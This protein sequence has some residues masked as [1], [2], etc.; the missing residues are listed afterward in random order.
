ML[1]RKVLSLATALGF[2]ISSVAIAQDATTPPPAAPPPAAPE[3]AVVGEAPA[4]APAAAAEEKTEE[5]VVTGTRIRRKDLTTPAPVT[6]ISSEQIQ[7]SGKVTIG[8]FLQSLPEQGN[9]I[10]T[11]VNNGGSGSTR[12]SLRALGAQRTLVLLNGRRMVPSGLGA[13]D[14]VDLSAIPSAVI[15]RVEVLKDGAS[16]VY[17]SDAIAGVVNLI[18]RKPFSGSEVSGYYG[19]SAQGDAQIADITGT[20]GTSGERGSLFFNVGWYDQRKSMAGDRDFSKDGWVYDS[21]GANTGFLGAVPQGSSR[22]PG[23]RIRANNPEGNANPA[24]LA[25]IQNPDYVSRWRAIGGSAYLIHD[26]TLTTD[27][28]AVANCMAALP[29][30]ASLSDCQWRPMDTRTSTT[31]GGDLYNF[32]PVNYL[33]TPSQRLSLWS[34]GDARLSDS[35]RAFFEAHFVNRQ[36]RVQL[37]PEPLIIGPGGVTDPGGNLVSIS[38]DNVYN[39]FGQKF[40]LSSR[41]LEE[42]GPRIQRHDVDTIRAV[43]GVDGTLSDAF[44]PVQGWFWDVNFNYGRNAST[45]T[46]NGNLQNSRIQA[47]LGESFR[48]PDGSAVCGNPGPDSVAGTGDDAV[49]AGCV[50]LDLFHGSGSITQDQVNYLTFTGTSKGLN[51]LGAIQANLNGELLTLPGADRP[52]GLALGYE[53]RELSGAFINDPFTA[54]FDNSNGGSFDT[55]GSYSVNEGYAELSVPVTAARPGVENLEVS[56]AARVFDYSTFGGDWTYKLGARYSPVRNFT[57]R[58][59]YSTAFR[60]PSISDLYAG[61]FDN[62]PNVSDPCAAPASAE[63]AARCGAAANNGDDSTQLR[64]TNGGNPALEPETA[65]IYTIGVVYEPP[66]LKNFSATLDYYNIA[67]DKA[68]ATIGE[69]TILAGCYTTGNQPSYCSLIERDPAS[70]QITRM[71]NLNQNVGEET[72]A[73][74]DLALRY[75]LPTAS[76]GR[77]NFVFD[78]TVL[79]KH[80]QVL[81]D[82]TVVKGKGTFD[83]QDSAGQ[84]GTNA[85]FKFNAGVLWGLRGFG[86]GLSTKFINGFRECAAPTGAYDGS[87]L[88]YVDDTF[89]RRVKAYNTYDL[90][91]S[92]GLKSALGRTSLSAGVNNLFDKDPAKIYNGFASATDQYTYDQIGRYF[93]VRLEQAY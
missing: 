63:I 6:V 73:G 39:P 56:L 17:G 10:N 69:S 89:S 12:V 76:A 80:N 14:S 45:F 21:T 75:L 36:S 51:K 29:A 71:T 37:A 34:S 79:Q 85:S 42:F 92:Y 43:L 8:D 72:A 1:R 53:Y 59:T 91:L 49:I 7:A 3:S 35:A 47:A 40:F 25:L 11:S 18:T 60:A 4:A 88:C 87:G 74:F 48:L 64:S 46:L 57:I 44:G 33:V 23:G 52:V 41:R 19:T 50:P 38:A 78:G 65:K 84:G 28:A 82:G 93:W 9:A 2:G 70:Q 55:S 90:F 67:V 20:A 66:F 30:G 62:F 61:Q 31:V 54:K 83:L 77:F 24:F 58:G 81:A 16:A 13:D 22:A 15:E 32:A 5:I 68:I 27:T 86:A 26:P